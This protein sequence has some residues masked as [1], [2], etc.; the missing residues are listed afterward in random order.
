MKYFLNASMGA[1][2]STPFIMS[3]FSLAWRTVGY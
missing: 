1:K 2:E 3:V